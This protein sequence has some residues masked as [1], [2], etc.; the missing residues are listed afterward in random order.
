MQ[1]LNKL[2]KPRALNTLLNKLDRQKLLKL[3]LDKLDKPISLKVLL[4]KLDKQKLL[5]LLLNALDEPDM[6]QGSVQQLELGKLFS[7]L[8][9]HSQQVAF[10]VDCIHFEY[11]W[12]QTDSYEFLH[13]LL[14]HRPLVY[15]RRNNYHHHHPTMLMIASSVF[16]WANAPLGLAWKGL[17]FAW[18]FSSVGGVIGIVRR[19]IELLEVINLVLVAVE[20]IVDCLLVLKEKIAQL[21]AA[22]EEKKKE[23]KGAGV[24]GGQGE[25]QGAVG[26]E[27]V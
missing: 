22:K 3:L 1:L 26:A 25:G 10:H 27:M 21:R 14:P 11:L 20:K 8:T 12:S 2:N 9:V 7:W 24:G 5:K 18:S 23:G 15:H 6:P 17:K 16:R 13:L 4:N 19:A